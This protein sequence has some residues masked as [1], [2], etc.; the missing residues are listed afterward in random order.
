MGTT[1]KKL[2]II[3]GTIFFIIVLFIIAIIY[4]FRFE[5][6]AITV[7]RK[8]LH[9]PA[10]IVDGTWISISEIDEN[11]TSI[12]KFYENQD[13]S[14]YGI[15]IDFTT[16]E[17]QKRL[18]IQEKKMLNKLI[19][20]IAIE[21]IAEEW[22]ISISNEAVKS[23]V[24]R[25]MSEMGSRDQ[26]KEKLDRLYGW[27][28]DDFS[29]KVVRGQLLREK[30]ALK[31]D[32]ENVISQNMRDQVAQAKKELDDGRSFADVAAKYSDG[33]TAQ[34]GGIMGWFS[35]DQLQDEIGKNIAQMTVGEISS[36]LETPLGLHIVQVN[37]ISEEDGQKKMVHVSQIIMKKKTFADFL[38][39]YIV[40]MHV[41]EFLPDYEWDNKTGL[42]VFSSNDMA[43]F[44][45][46]MQ[47]EV[48]A[49]QQQSLDK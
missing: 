43:D 6:P 44:E 46:K 29:N 2:F 9:L 26:I 34:E 48:I 27:S 18:K 4:F 36:V 33:V 38:A 10:I 49:A 32:Q 1:Y 5:S 23:A 17:G 37:D 12:K 40:D 31:F 15:R 42:F 3:T 8:A 22:G 24:E 14:S 11:T 47:E 28:L 21:E 25:P 20:D 13:F 35:E 30:V 39:E 7:V 41:K 19:E 45:K 16:D